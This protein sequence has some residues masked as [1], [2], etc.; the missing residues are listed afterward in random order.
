MPRKFNPKKDYSS[1]HYCGWF[2]QR[3]H[4]ELL[5]RYRRAFNSGKTIY[6]TLIL[7]RK[8]TNF[9]FFYFSRFRMVSIFSKHSI[10]FSNVTKYSILNTIRPSSKWCISSTIMCL[11]I[12]EILNSTSL[13]WCGKLRKKLIF[14]SSVNVRE[15]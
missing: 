1:I 6:F 14:Q 10:C 7:Y 8:S 12:K 3:K 2:N 13:Q 4:Y 5:H 15:T 11:R 9:N